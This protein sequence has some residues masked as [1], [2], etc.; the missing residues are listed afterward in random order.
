MKK[1]L[2]NN[3]KLIDI[4]E[5]V[6]TDTYTCPVCHEKLE[7]KFG[8]IKQ[9]YAHP[10]GMGEDCEIKMKLIIKEE[11]KQLE[12]SETNILK[13]QFYN[14]TFNDISIEMSDYKSEDG[15]FLTKE[16]NNIIFST[17]DRIKISALA[18]SAK[19]STLYYYA[20][21]RPFKK[22]L[23]LVYNKAMKD[24][25]EKS[26]GRLKHLDIKTM[27]GLAYSYVGKYYKNKLTFNYGVVDI[28]KDLNLNWNKD[29]ELAV[30]INENDETIYVIGCRRI[31]RHR[32]V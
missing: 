28:I 5:S 25:A 29:M 9:Y 8:V 16:Q 2:N 4:I 32:N 18:G 22:I 31:F 6:S 26:F 7:R 20:K 15:Y 24:E 13:E 19:S 23:Y 12:E 1:A 11:E 21:E 10:K 27:H 17:E 30:K 14:N 3:G